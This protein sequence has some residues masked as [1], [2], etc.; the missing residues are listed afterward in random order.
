[1]MYLQD[2]KQTERTA[3]RFPRVG[4]PTLEGGA[5][6]LFGIIF[7]ENCMKMNRLYLGV[8]GGRGGAMDARS[9]DPPLHKYEN[10]H[11]KLMVSNVH[12]LKK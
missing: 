3:C 4:K 2:E 11:E 9:Q 12:L 6:L 10:T 8:G 5:N 7:T 1:M